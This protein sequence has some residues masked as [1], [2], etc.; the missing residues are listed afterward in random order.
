MAFVLAKAV[1][2]VGLEVIAEEP[3]PRHANIEHWPWNE[4]DLNDQKSRQKEIAVTL[5]GEA[6][7]VVLGIE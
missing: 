4:G 6:D 1:R 7:L 5:V 3:P 2:H